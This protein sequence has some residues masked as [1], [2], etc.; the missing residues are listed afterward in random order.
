MNDTTSSSSVLAKTMDLEI[1]LFIYKYVL[2]AQTLFGGSGNIFN[3]IVLLSRNMRSRTNLLFALMAF[4][5]LSFLLIQSIHVLYVHRIVQK[6]AWYREAQPLM[7]GLTNWF[8]ALSIWCLLYAT[9]ERVQA[10]RSPFRAASKQHISRRFVSTLLCISAG[11]LLLTS[12]HFANSK[13]SF[14]RLPQFVRE[15]MTWLNALLVV[16]LPCIISIFLNTLLIHALKKPKLF[17]TQKTAVDDKSG[18]RHG[19]SKNERKMTLMVVVILTSFI[20]FNFPGAVWFVV[21]DSA[22]TQ[23]MSE[24]RLRLVETMTNSLTITG[25]MLNFVLFCSASSTFRRIFLAYTPCP[26]L[27][28]SS[29]TFIF[30]MSNNVL[31]MAANIKRPQGNSSRAKLTASK[32]LSMLEIHEQLEMDLLEV[33]PTSEGPTPRA[34]FRRCR[35]PSTIHVAKECND[36]DLQCQKSSRSQLHPPFSIIVTDSG[37]SII[38]DD[39]NQTSNDISEICAFV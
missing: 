17:P 21:R 11:S 34:S 30:A 8:S 13:K 28:A 36:I 9:V 4:A 7:T 5:D 10:L 38:A 16:F 24:T 12:F 39:C 37:E 22:L 26:Q 3:L 20:I 35:R 32:S 19:H 6:G 25:K 29:L 14:L 1:I 18:N 33:A 27:F 23:S 2:L 31:R 15:S